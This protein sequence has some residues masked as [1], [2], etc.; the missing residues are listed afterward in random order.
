MQR[1][2]LSALV[3][4]FHSEFDREEDVALL[5]KTGKAGM[6]Q[7]QIAQYVS[8]KFMGVKSRLR[9]YPST[10]YYKNEIIVAEYLSENKLLALYNSCDCF[11]MPSQTIL[12]LFFFFLRLSS[13]RQYK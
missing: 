12:L 1:K 9:I 3:A 8:D 2:N 6:N 13:F 11:V 5:I 10:E 7:A 4:A